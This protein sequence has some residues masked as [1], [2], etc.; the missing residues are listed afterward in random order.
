VERIV[1]EFQKKV[2]YLFAVLSAFIFLLAVVVI[3][4]GVFWGLGAYFF[5]NVIRLLLLAPVVVIL[6]AVIY[7]GFRTGKKEMMVIDENG[8]TLRG[9]TLIGPI[10][11]DCFIPWGSIYD[12]DIVRKL[13]VGAQ[14]VLYLTNLSKIEIISEK[15]KIREIVKNNKKTGEKIITID[16]SYYWIKGID[17]RALI[18]ERAAGC[19]E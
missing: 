8:L 12:A 6:L 4:S 11:Y 14:L 10:L 19:K 5:G 1:V 9:D 7:R 2:F 3:L 17:L 16:L 18:R 13:F 15:G